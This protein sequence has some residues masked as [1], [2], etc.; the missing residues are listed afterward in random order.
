MVEAGLLA[1]LALVIWRIGSELG[2]RQHGLGPRHFVVGRARRRRVLVLFVVGCDATKV[3]GAVSSTID[4]SLGVSIIAAKDKPRTATFVRF[5]GPDGT[6]L[7]RADAVGRT[8]AWT[9]QEAQVVLPQAAAVVARVA[10]AVQREDAAVAVVPVDV[11]QRQAVVLAAM[12]LHWRREDVLDRDLT[13][14][15]RHYPAREE[16]RVVRCEHHIAVLSHRY[17]EAFAA[18]VLVVVVWEVAF[19]LVARKQFA[20]IKGAASAQV[21]WHGGW[22]A[23]RTITIANITQIINRSSEWNS[24]AIQTRLTVTGTD[25]TDVVDIWTVWHTSAIQARL[26]V[27]TA[28]VAHVV[29]RVTHWRVVA[30][31]TRVAV[32]AA[33]VARVVAASARNGSAT[34]ATTLAIATAHVAHV[35]TLGTKRSAAAIQARATVAGAHVTHIVSVSTKRNVAA[36]QT[37][38]AVAGAHIAL[39]VHVWSIGNASAIQTRVAVSTTNV[40]TIVVVRTVWNAETICT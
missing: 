31:E 13:T 7:D 2:Q 4:M 24:L 19:K 28:H 35:V 26:A 39:I 10:L 14:I 37:R 40:A 9:F 12:M 8:A 38:L 17:G 30:I 11:V 25:V 29:A 32:T 18:Q 36:I 3:R 1:V 22:H 5:A 21:Q 16:R 27:A 33:H 34:I 15:V 23:R 20:A 6:L